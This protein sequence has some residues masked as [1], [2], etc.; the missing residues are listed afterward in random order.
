MWPFALLLLAPLLAVVASGCRDSK[1]AQ[2][3]P[4]AAAPGAAV[5]PVT[6][7][8]PEIRTRA[9]VLETTGKVQF[10]EEQLVRVN[11]PVTG[12]VIEVLAR[13]GE[14]VE[15][16]HPLFVLDSA[17]LGQ[18]KSDYAKAV[19][20]LA[21]SERA[22]KLAKDLFEMKAIAE[23]DIREAEND[24]NKSLAERDR[25][26][27]RLRTLGIRPDQLKDI[28][29]RADASTT[30]TVRAPRSG[31][32]VER[33]ISP[34]Q[35]VSYGQSDTPVSLFVIA[36]LSTMWVVADVYEPDVPKVRLGQAM[37]V[38]LPCCPQDRYAGKVVHIGAA[39]DKDSRTVK[40]RAVVTNPGG[41]LKGEMFVRVAID[42]GSWQVLTL[43]QSAIQRADGSTFV[44]LEKG[45]GE[46]ERR[47]VK[48][49]PDF[50]GVTEVV[51]GVT[52][53]D[54]VVSTGG[55]LLKRDAR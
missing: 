10:D 9:A 51:D 30:V 48:T 28:A 38:T 27:A 26:A 54:R 20:D 33:N 35:V 55:V 40:V 2:V 15:T 53:Q 14:L 19:S 1:S 47:S 25:A 45:K 12:R 8:R 24:H 42:T 7:V 23:K 41:V 36:N 13:P 29:D 39:V 32:I 21:R 46:Y 4:P 44:L 34:G 3:A 31:V 50:D 5:N 49:G 6:V 22:I 37:R 11:A 16:G 17:D 43:P 52:A 18:A